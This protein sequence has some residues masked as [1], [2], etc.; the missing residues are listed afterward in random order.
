MRIAGMTQDSIVDGPGLRFTVFMQG[1][2]FHCVGCQ[3][4]Q[5]HDPAGGVDF[6]M[7]ELSERMRSNPLTKG[8]TLSGGEPF[9]QPEDCLALSKD[10]HEAGLNVWCFTGWVFED[11][12]SHGTEAQKIFLREIDVLVDGPFLLEQQ[13]LALP[14]RGSRNQRL[15]DVPE[16]LKKGKTVLWQPEAENSN[17]QS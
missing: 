9:D 2:H 14:W 3:N 16:S 17:I 13:T 8:L 1:C 5:T 4:P 10:A 7:E 6:P 12:L 11:L 15:I